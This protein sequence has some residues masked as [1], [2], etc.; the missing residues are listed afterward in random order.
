MR[1]KSHIYF[2]LALGLISFT[3]CS[4]S[5]Q[6]GSKKNHKQKNE[7]YQED[8]SNYRLKY[9][10]DTAKETRQ[11]PA[12]ATVT[13]V[14]PSKDDTKELSARLDTI[15]HKQTRTAPGYRVLI[16]SGK[17]SEE[18]KKARAK[19][20]EI[21]PDADIYTD[22]KSPNQRVKVGDALDRVE[23]NMLY[24]KL[25]KAFPNAVIIPDNI[26]IKAK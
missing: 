1:I 8:I 20:Y 26:V 2:L 22:F 12:K 13:P 4:S 25:K 18:V 16:Y 9:N 7:A 11:E 23:V 5:A 10:T 6:S 24:G 21:L 17:S 19:V 3:G 14:A 15:A